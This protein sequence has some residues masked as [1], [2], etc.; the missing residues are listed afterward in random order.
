MSEEAAQGNAMDVMPSIQQL[1]GMS[2]FSIVAYKQ[3]DIYE[4]LLRFR[5][6]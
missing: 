5:I 1:A 4:L 2:S 3:F 6:Q